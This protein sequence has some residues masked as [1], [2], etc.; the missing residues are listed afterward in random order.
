MSHHLIDVVV[1]CIQAALFALGVSGKWHAAAIIVAVLFKAL[2][3]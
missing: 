1:E 3:P 2:A